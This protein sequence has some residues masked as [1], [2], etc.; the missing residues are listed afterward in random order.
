MDIW[1]GVVSGYK[2][3]TAFMHQ[4]GEQDDEMERFLRGGIHD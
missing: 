3:R 4:G 2:L 1:T